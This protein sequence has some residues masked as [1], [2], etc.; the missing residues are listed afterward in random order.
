MVLSSYVGATVKRKEDPRLITGSS[1]YV[2]DL[3]LAG[4]VHVAFV[5]S[6]YAHARIKGIDTAAAL[7]MPGVVAVVTARGPGDGPVKDK[8]PVDPH[9]ETGEDGA[10]EDAAMEPGSRSRGVE[11]L[12]RSKVRYVGEPVAAVVAETQAQAAGRRR[13]GRGR[14]RAA[15]R[16]SSIRTR[17]GRT[18]APLLYDNVKNNISV[19]Q[20]T[21]PR[22]RRCARWPAR[23]SRSRRSIRAPRCHPMPMEPRGIV[24]AP[25]PITR[26]LTV[27]TSTQAPHGYRNEIAGGAR[28]G[29]EPGAGD[30]AG[31]R[32]R[33]RLQVRR[34]SRGLR[35]LRRWRCS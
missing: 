15:A 4:M 23:R 31:G 10:E 35:R 32:R 29:A 26:G 14:L 11:P 28:A 17:R 19:R 27:W 9:G 22:R 30:R 13:A 18:G 5:R 2:D 24:A 21:R 34:L 8:Y 25:D 7:A 3:K 12:A 16:R 33:L 20:E 6:P 1:I